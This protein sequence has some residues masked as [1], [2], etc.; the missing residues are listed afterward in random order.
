MEFFHLKIINTSQGYIHKYENLKRKL[1][2]CNV[3]IYFN[4]QMLKCEIS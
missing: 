1:Y 4:Q 2:S 3:N